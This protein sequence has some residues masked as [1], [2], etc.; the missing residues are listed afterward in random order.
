MAMQR[1]STT[2]TSV[3]SVRIQ[4]LAYFPNSYDLNS[5]DDWSDNTRDILNFMLNY[6]PDSADESLPTHLP[7]KPAHISKSR[8]QDGFLDRVL[9]SIAH[10]F[11]GCTTYVSLLSRFVRVT[12]DLPL[13]IE[14][15]C[16]ALAAINCPT[17]FSSLIL[18]DPIILSPPP[19][20]VAW[21]TTASSRQNLV[22]LLEGALTRRNE[23]SSR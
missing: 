13:I 12:S 5:V 4:N 15:A 10:S 16:R 7:R 2:L 21:I 3:L 17:L 11:G 22:K 6:M 20:N 14:L 23:W 1:C 9:V 18:I 8:E 19:P